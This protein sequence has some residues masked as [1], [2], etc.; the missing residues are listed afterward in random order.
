[1]RVDMDERSREIRERVEGYLPKFRLFTPAELNYLDAVAED[2]WK[3]FVS[4]LWLGLDWP[5]EYKVRLEKWNILIPEE[6]Y[7]NSWLQLCA[8][9][10]G[11]KRDFGQFLFD[12]VVDIIEYNARE[13]NDVV[14][15]SKIMN[16]YLTAKIEF[17]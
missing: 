12:L 17:N 4:V 8:N 9:R 10:I 6:D 7:F 14:V 3:M 1:M 16:T 15:M 2:F 11:N 13:L 5:E